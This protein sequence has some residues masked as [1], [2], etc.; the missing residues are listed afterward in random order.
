MSEI[1]EQPAHET[2]R[3]AGWVN[4]WRAL[5]DVRCLNGCGAGARRGE[6]YFECACIPPFLSKSEAE[7]EAADDLMRQIAD[8]GKL[9]NEWLGAF[10]R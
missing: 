8:Y 1:L 5:E 2:R 4:K 6:T 9:L 7:A 3:V 10:P